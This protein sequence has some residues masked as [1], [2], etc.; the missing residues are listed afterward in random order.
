MVLTLCVNIVYR[1]ICLKLS[2]IIDNSLMKICI[3]MEQVPSQLH[4]FWLYVSLAVQHVK[5][6]DHTVLSSVACTTIC[7][8]HLINGTIFGQ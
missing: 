4:G 1:Q 2:V 6:M 7:P 8:H 3:D 5:C